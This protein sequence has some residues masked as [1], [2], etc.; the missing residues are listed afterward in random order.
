MLKMIEEQGMKFDIIHAYLY[1]AGAMATWLWLAA[2]KKHDQEPPST[3][4]TIFM[5]L[6]WCVLVPWSLAM[7]I[8]GS[9]ARKFTRG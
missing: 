6:S 8:A 5:V 1:A 3:G 9:V 2:M 7:A 4:E